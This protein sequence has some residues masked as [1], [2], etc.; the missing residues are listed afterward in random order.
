MIKYG[1]ISSQRLKRDL[2]DWDDLYLAGRMHKPTH[3]LMY[4]A[5]VTEH[6]CFNI[7]SALRVALLSLPHKFSLRELLH[8]ICMLSY[9]GDFR[10]RFAEDSKKVDRIVKGL[11]RI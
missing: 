10:M 4:D 6:Q 5:S 11:F 8:Q 7:Q 9:L 3:T 2:I 1:V